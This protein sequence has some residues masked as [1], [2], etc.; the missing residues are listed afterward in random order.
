MKK[1]F[2]VLLFTYLLFTTNLMC[3]NQM[4]FAQ[5]ALPN[6]T[7]QNS[8]HGATQ[9]RM[10]R[11]PLLNTFILATL[12]GST[13]AAT[14]DTILRATVVTAAGVAVATYMGKESSMTRTE[15]LSHSIAFICGW[16][17]GS[18]IGDQVRSAKKSVLG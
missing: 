18:I 7:L 15:K 16:A 11:Y 8:F 6:T 5:N 2:T 1:Q 12:V 14:N 9:L 3:M 13:G 17:T 10:T 4:T